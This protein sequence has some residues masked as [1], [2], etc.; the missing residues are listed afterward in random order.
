MGGI[1]FKGE[2]PKNHAEIDTILNNLQERINEPDNCI[3]GEGVIIGE[4]SYAYLG[5]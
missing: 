2:S 3:T 1:Q 5:D 4:F